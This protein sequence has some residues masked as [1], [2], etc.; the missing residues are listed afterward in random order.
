MGKVQFEIR[1]H[2][3]NYS[4]LVNQFW[5]F[6][7]IVL[8]S[9]FWEKKYLKK[10]KLEFSFIRYKFPSYLFLFLFLFC[11]V[12]QL[13]HRSFVCILFFYSCDVTGFKFQY[14]YFS[15]FRETGLEM[16]GWWVRLASL[17]WSLYK[18]TSH[19]GVFSLNYFSSS[20]Q[21]IQNPEQWIL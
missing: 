21:S 12:F 1:Y 10:K 5:Y 4:F 19:M 14:S 16:C 17:G 13:R 11:D 7:N 2:V 9:Y 15:F 20:T 18:I 3:P 6:L 8:Y